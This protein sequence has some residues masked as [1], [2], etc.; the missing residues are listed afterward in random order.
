MFNSSETN[1]ANGDYGVYALNLT[2]NDGDFAQPQ[3]AIMVP[4]S[5]SIMA[6][7][8]VLVPFAFCAVRIVRRNQ[9]A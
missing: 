7:V 5:T 1:N 6:E 3:L 9:A 2:G 8:L 4:D